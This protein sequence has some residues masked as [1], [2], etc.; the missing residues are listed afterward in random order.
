MFAMADRN[1][2]IGRFSIGIEGEKACHY[3]KKLTDCHRNDSKYSGEEM[4]SKFIFSGHSNAN[5]NAFQNGPWAQLV[6][7]AYLGRK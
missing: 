4:S 6:Q 2:S 1:K 7:A 3:D 5:G